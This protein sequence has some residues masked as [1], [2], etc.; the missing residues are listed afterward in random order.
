MAKALRKENKQIDKKNEKIKQQYEKEIESRKSYRK[1]LYKKD[2][3]HKPKRFFYGKN[4]SKQL[5]K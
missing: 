3:S 5:S 4:K 2:T 1:T